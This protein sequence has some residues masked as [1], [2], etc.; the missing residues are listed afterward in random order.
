MTSILNLARLPA[1]LDSQQASELLGVQVHDLPTLVRAGLLKP[2]ASPKPNAPKFFAAV[3]LEELGRNRN[4]LEKAQRAI[5]RHWQL[6][7]QTTCGAKS[8]A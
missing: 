7:N 3:E 2:L 5:Q 4:W 6:K 1:R 8:T